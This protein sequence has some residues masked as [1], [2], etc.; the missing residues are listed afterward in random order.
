MPNYI[1]TLDLGEK[2]YN[3]L[4]TERTN[5]LAMQEINAHIIDIEFY[6]DPDITEISDDEFN[7]FASKRMVLLKNGTVNKKSENE[8]DIEFLEDKIRNRYKGMHIQNGLVYRVWENYNFCDMR[9]LGNRLRMQPYTISNKIS[10]F[11]SLGE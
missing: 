3:F 11:I 9:S 6:G 8:V 5:A 2:C 4:C 7:L 1:V 10:K